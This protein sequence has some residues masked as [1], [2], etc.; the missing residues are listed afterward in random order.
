[1]TKKPLILVAALLL[2]AA[3]LCTHI[4]Q[5]TGDWS[6]GMPWQGLDSAKQ[7]EELQQLLAD[8]TA[9]EVIQKVA[10]LVDAGAQLDAPNPGGY[11]PIHMA[12]F[13]GHAGAMQWLLD[14]GCPIDSRTSDG[15]QPLHEAASNGR[16]EIVKLLLDNGANVNAVT[17][18]GAQPLH[19]AAIGGSKEIAALLIK[20]GASASNKDENGQSPYDFTD[21]PE[22][23]NLLVAAGAPRSAPSLFEATKLGRQLSM[24]WLT[25]DGLADM[26]QL[27]KQLL[28]AGA[29]P[30]VVDSEGQQAIHF[31]TH[32]AEIMALLIEKGAS[33]NARNAEGQQPL[34]LAVSE[35]HIE[36]V[37]L[38]LAKGADPQAQDSQG[39]TAAEIAD[40][41]EMRALLQ[42]S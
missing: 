13:G 32:N 36:T 14:N 10:A 38:L 30:D 39:M 20:A 4:D 1:M 37:R 17:L 9:T 3:V 8:E 28:E 12:I 34:M 15:T 27:A 21:D 23:R 33:V 18:S 25:S 35:G 19:Y 11:L 40:T 41:D 42:G 6:F 2:V 24:L 7:N 29:K 31:M 26:D 22:L 16:L 5:D